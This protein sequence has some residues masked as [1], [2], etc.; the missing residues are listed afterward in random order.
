MS[1][2]SEGTFLVVE[3]LCALQDGRLLSGS[4]DQTIRVWNVQTG[5]A[6][7]TIQQGGMVMTVCQ[8][9]DGVVA[10]GLFDGSIRLLE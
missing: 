9:P 8:L 5:Q 6:E 3:S 10:I 7:M 2:D 1:E 4:W